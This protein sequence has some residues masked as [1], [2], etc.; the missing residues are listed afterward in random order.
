MRMS[1]TSAPQNDFDVCIVGTGVAGLTIARE[2]LPAGVRVCLIESG[3]EDFDEDQQQLNDAENIGFDYYKII[4]CRLRIFG[5]TTAIWGGR[6]APLDAIDFQK[7]DWVPHSGWPISIEDLAQPYRKARQ[8]L[9][10]PAYGVQEDL[11]RRKRENFH[12][13]NEDGFEVTRWEFDKKHDRFQM[14]NTQDVV[15][16]RDCTL[17]L[18]QTVVNINLDAETGKKVKSVTIRNRRGED[19]EIRAKRFVLATGG[20]ENPRLLLNARDHHKEGIGNHNGLVGRFFMEHPRVR[21][22]AIKA[23]KPLAILRASYRMETVGGVK[24]VSLIRPTDKFQEEEKVLNHGVTVMAIKPEGASTNL[25]IRFY[26]GLRGSLSPSKGNRFLWRNMKNFALWLN[27]QAEPYISAVLVRLGLRQ[28]NVIIRAEQAPNIESR[29]ILSAEK[30]H[31]GMRRVKLDW[32]FSEIDKESV[33]VITQKFGEFLEKKKL[34]SV[35]LASWLSDPDKEWEVDPLIGF[36]HIG[37]YHHMGTTRMAETDAEGVVDKN[38]KVF[39]T[40]NLYIAGCSVFPTGGWGNPT[41]TIAA[42]A[43][44]LGDHLN[45]L[46]SQDR[47]EG[48]SNVT[49]LDKARMEKT[50]TAVAAKS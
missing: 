33:R 19:R 28:L 4:D 29:V 49:H 45:D 44:R 24:T 32:R 23:R 2:L 34:G 48:Y 17:M 9:G 7:R 50:K 1:D 46:A 3:G 42:L 31:M 43:V 27:R 25:V 20:L 14:D 40:E 13:M 12:G 18:R 10:L 39:G 15:K 8:M 47:L 6:C 37:G 35:K 21:G 5:G 38:C 30:D 16:N 22:G 26:N 41:L 11:V 36:H